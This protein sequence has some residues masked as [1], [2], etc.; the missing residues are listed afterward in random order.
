MDKGTLAKPPLH[1]EALSK[2]HSAVFADSAR[3]SFIF[4]RGKIIITELKGE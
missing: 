1:L 3:T 2:T 4:Q